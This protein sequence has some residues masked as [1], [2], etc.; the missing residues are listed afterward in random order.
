MPPFPGLTQDSITASGSSDSA[1]RKS[2]ASRA[3]ANASA[4]LRSKSDRSIR[5]AGELEAH[6]GWIAKRLAR[7]N[8]LPRGA[9]ND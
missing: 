5:A 1:A 4:P 8:W 6:M 9:A 3:C 2:F 7:A